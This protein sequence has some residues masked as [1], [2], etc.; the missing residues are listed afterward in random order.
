MRRMVGTGLVLAALVVAGS[1]CGSNSGESAP[2]GDASSLVGE[3]SGKCGI[4]D[5][6]G[7]QVGSDVDA[8]LGFTQDGKYTQTISGPDGANVNGTYTVGGQTITLTAE[9]SALKADY[10]IKDG[11]LTTTT[12]DSSS[13]TPTTSTCTLRRS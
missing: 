11:V 8:K 10:A 3:W 2:G 1:A 9:G 12:Q 4:K 6:S 5:Q 7:K 13:G